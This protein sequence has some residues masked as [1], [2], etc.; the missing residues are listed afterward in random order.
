MAG[1]LMMALTI[2]FLL[3]ASVMGVQAMPGGLAQ[4]ASNPDLLE[5]AVRVPSPKVPLVNGI[6]P[7][8]TTRTPSATMSRTHPGKPLV[9]GITVAPGSNNNGT[10]K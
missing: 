6:P 10:I 4:R 3:P 1:K 5:V 9:N 7:I 8:T 2:C